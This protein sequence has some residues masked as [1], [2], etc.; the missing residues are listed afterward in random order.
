MSHLPI[1]PLRAPNIA[2]VSIALLLALSVVSSR[3]QAAPA[4]A[5]E[6]VRSFYA[7]LLNTMTNGPP[8]GPSGRYAALKPAVRK[9][10]NIPL[11][12]R[13][14]IGPGWG[15]LTLDQQQQVTE[16]LARYVAATYADRF[17]NYSGE[18]LQVAG[19]QP[20]G[21]DA[22]V[23]TRIVK[24]K[25]E[26]VGINYLVQRTAT[27]WQISDVYLDGTIS[28]LATRRADFSAILRDR[29]IGGLIAALNRKADLLS[30]RS[31]K[32]S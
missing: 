14:A 25:G 29:G 4:D 28:E 6:V 26:P 1:P 3:A 32:T 27:T 15:S 20:F 12:A 24:S 21:A 22:I 11:M 19:E 9:T 2:K 8:L 7:T 5:A 10:F 18:K 16:A 30:A 23:Q 31:A 13:V 17:D